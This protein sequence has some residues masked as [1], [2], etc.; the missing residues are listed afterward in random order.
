MMTNSRKLPALIAPAVTASA[1]LLVIDRG[2]MIAWGTLLV[3]AVLF[4]KIWLKPSAADLKLCLSL[5]AVSVLAWIGTLGYVISTWESAEVVELTIETRSGPHTAR[6]WVLDMDDQP[7]IYYDATA[8]AAESLLAGAPLQLVRRGA[9]SRRVP[10]ARKAAD[11]PVAEAEQIIAAMS[12]KYG[13]RVDAA[14]IWYLMLGRSQ[15]RVAV[16]ARLAVM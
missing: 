16:V 11:L 1:G 12:M 15:D 6:V 4:T 10:K 13:R 7:V 3:G 8:A 9:V 2:G 5:V 14:D